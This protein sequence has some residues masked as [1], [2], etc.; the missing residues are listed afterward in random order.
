MSAGVPPGVIISCD[1]LG[2]RAPGDERVVSPPFALLLGA[3]KDTSNGLKPRLL[4]VAKAASL[5]V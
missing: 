4:K 5:D 2:E 1:A 3:P